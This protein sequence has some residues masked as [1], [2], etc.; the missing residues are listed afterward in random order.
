MMPLG[1]EGIQTSEWVTDWPRTCGTGTSNLTESLED[2]IQSQ[3]YSSLS[4]DDTPGIGGPM[5]FRSGNGLGQELGDS[6]L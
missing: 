3:E 1:W 6:D 4:L 5:D 2:Q